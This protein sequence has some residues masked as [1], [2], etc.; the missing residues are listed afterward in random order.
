MAAPSEDLMS[1]HQYHQ[2]SQ[3]EVPEIRIVQ[4]VLY[5]II[6]RHGKFEVQITG[7]KRKDRTKDGA[8]FC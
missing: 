2:S 7:A 5:G 8:R 3:V 6:E 4:D 1:C